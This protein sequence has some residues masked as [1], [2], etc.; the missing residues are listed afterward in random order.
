MQL[1]SI[2]DRNLIFLDYHFGSYG[3]LIDFIVEKMA[4][5]TGL[6]R[7]VVREAIVRREHQGTTYI[8]HRLI[9]PHGYAEA[10]GDIVVLFVRLEKEFSVVVDNRRRSVKY[11]FAI[12]TAKNKAQLYLKV[13]KSVANVVSN[14]TYLID[15]AKTPDDLIAAMDQRELEIEDLLTA[16]D[17]ISCDAATGTHDTVLQAID[18]MESSGLCILPVVNN[19]GTLEGVLDLADL[20]I[21]T[22]PPG[23]V[24]PESLALLYEACALRDR[25][26]EQAKKHWQKEQTTFVRSLMRSGEPYA[27]EAGAQYP[28]IVNHMTRYRQRFA[29]VV[30][31]HKRVLGLIDADDLVH[32]MIRA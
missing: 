1:S 21:A 20:F 3:E 8:G 13:L 27:I 29:V 9:L 17:F 31:A 19:E 22:H 28:D 16:R 25:V 14:Y 11:I 4:A 26:L 2:L 12:M 18:R 7:D 32:R 6:D 23:M 15:N 5:A 24:D 10:I 30:D